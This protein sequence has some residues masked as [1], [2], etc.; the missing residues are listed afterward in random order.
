M[1]T[2]LPPG[3]CVTAAALAI[4]A[5]LLLSCDDGGGASPKRSGPPAVP[6]H[7]LVIEAQALPRTISSVGG[8]ESPEMT[9]VSSEIAGTVMKLDIR[10]GERVAAGHVV[11][12]LDDAEAHAA[13]T[14]T[15]ARLK[16]AADRLARVRK[17][18][19]Q[20][21]ASQQQL[22]DAAST[23]DAAEGAH[24]EA[25]TRLAKHVLRA[26]YAG[27]LGLRQ[28]DLG[29]YVKPGD[30]IVEISE[31]MALELR[32]SLPQRHVGDVRTGQKV[33]G[34]AGRCG[35]RFEGIVVAIDPRVDPR[36]RMV[37]LRAAV[38]NDAAALHPGMAVRVRLVV[39]TLEDALMIPQEAV[40]RQ[41]TKHLVFLVEDDKAQPREVTLG[42]YFVDGVHVISGIEAGSTVVLAGQQKLR[43]GSAVK[44]VPHEPVTNPNVDVG[45]FGPLGCDRP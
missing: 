24:E 30:P 27:Q 41:G 16:N 28:V 36:T 8:L 44:P 6:V 5:A 35:P 19:G 34:I 29:D 4:A 3:P 2:R 40:V 1:P 14:V 15:R 21:V 31:T 11:L 37:G 23:F 33:L 38:P 22:D 25:S 10:E 45:N 32:F 18:S 17:L 9:T 7:T 20:G 43:P 39:D 12:R 42:E 26:P 13:F